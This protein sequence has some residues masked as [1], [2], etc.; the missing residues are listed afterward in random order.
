[1][2]I[3]IHLDVESLQAQTQQAW[4]MMLM[5]AASTCVAGDAASLGL[6]EVV[7]HSMSI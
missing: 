2:H 4:S 6:N 7:W 5:L 3:S 1:M